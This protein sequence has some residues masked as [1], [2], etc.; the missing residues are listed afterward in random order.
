MTLSLADSLAAVITFY[1]GLW[2]TGGGA[3]EKIDWP[4]TISL[5]VHHHGQGMTR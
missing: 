3:H 2:I 5:E 1:A 4:A